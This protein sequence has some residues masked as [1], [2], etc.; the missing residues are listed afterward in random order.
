MNAAQQTAAAKEFADK[1]KG[2]GYE[3]GQTQL[4][5]GELLQKV[6]GVEN[7]ADYMECEVQVML[8][9]TSFID[10]YLPRT[11]VMIEQKSLG[12]DLSKPIKQS[13]GTQLTPMQQLKRYAAALGFFKYPRW[14][15]TCNFAEFYIYDMGTPNSEPEIIKLEDLP[16]EY[17]RMNFLVDTSHDNIKKEL[18]VSLNAGKITG[19][20]YEILL[21][22]Y[23]DEPTAKMLKSLN[24]LVVRLVF[25]MYAEDSGI[26][27]KKN[28]F[29]GYLK[30]VMPVHFRKVLIELFKILDT[31]I[32]ERDPYEEKK[33]LEFPYV[34]GGLFS[35]ENI[36]V[37]S[38]DQE[39]IDNIIKACEFDWSEISP[40]IFGAIFESTIANQARRSG[41]MHYTSVENIHKVIDPLFLNE[42][43][44]EYEK[45]LDS[46]D[47]N[48][49]KPRLR[50][51]QDKLA[52]LTFF[53]PACGSGNFLTETYISLR[54]L[55]NQVIEKLLG[56][57][58]ILG[59]LANPVKVSIKQFY[60][61]EINDYACVVAKTA[62]WIAELQM[63]QETQAL[64]HM[65]L[66]FLPL[67][68]YA[69]I[70]EG[71]AL[72][73]DWNEI[74][75][76]EKLN[77]IMGNPPFVGKSF[78]TPEQKEDMAHVFSGIK[79]FGN[80]DFVASWYK[81]AADYMEGTKI[82]CAFVS[83]NSICQG[84][85]VPPLWQYMFQKGIFINF[86]H[87]T[88]KW[89]SEASEKA[90]VYCVII[91][92]SYFSAKNKWLF[93]G[94]LCTA[95]ENINAYLMVADNIIITDRHEPLGNVP[96]MAVGSFPT[97]GGNLVIQEDEYEDFINKEP[98]AKQYI[99]LYIG[100]DEFIKNRKRYCLWL[101]DCPPQELKQMPL[102]LKRI[103]GVRDFRLNSK[104]AQTRS[105]A[106]APTL[107]AEDRQ[108]NDNYILLPRTSSENRRYLP[109]GFM[110]A[111][112]IA[113]DVIILP[114]ATLFLFGILASNVH[115]AWMR[116]FCGRMKNDYRYSNTLVY[117][118]LPFPRVS[119]KQIAKIES[120]AQGILDARANHSGASMAA[121]YDE[122]TMPPDLRKAHHANDK[123]VMEAYG[124]WGKF[125]SKDKA[126]NEAACVAELMKMYQKLTA[127]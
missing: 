52:S 83:T 14:G 66:D 29:T 59:D 64:V 100:P 72:R 58:M 61:I 23:G 42:L 15:I 56:Q 68:S 91:G 65:N 109:I 79:N 43:K 85:A 89:D 105:R 123:A 63:M 34:N 90:A 9:H 107:F 103:Q 54:R 118:T 127:Q 17:S 114:N 47:E 98:N 38:F 88:F 37:P 122:L 102:V 35:D 94:G 104:K 55:E 44:A 62:L 70:V 48:K 5:W 26:F 32:K 60:G 27:G 111:D 18:E 28:M 33:L 77:Y 20:L 49:I 81:K 51:F 24:L 11:K 112:V 10:V 106:E 50:I 6:Y 31:P 39:C 45:I 117:N 73:L 4:F 36:I 21:K 124:F 8:E 75:S 3:K 97:D 87:K 74:I 25:C 2:K 71:N 121:L 101:K 120:T 116:A 67:K 69:N 108:P 40:T 16:K 19:K 41:G 125:T 86:A 1:W 22:Q 57:E 30:E 93:S 99:R 84:I 92:F 80:L 115:N 119:D 82:S 95:A 113:G 53:D 46:N 7:P 76:K 110:G 13:D 12:K 126:E 96:K 78:Q